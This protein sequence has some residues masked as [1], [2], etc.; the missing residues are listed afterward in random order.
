MNSMRVFSQRIVYTVA[1]AALLLALIIPMVASAATVTERSI[2]L[3]SASKGATNVSYQVA[4]TADQAAGAFVI[5]F[6]SNT[7]L[8]GED[9]DAPAGMSV[10]GAATTTPDYTLTSSDT[11]NPRIVVTSDLAIGE[12]ASLD[13]TGITNPSAS[14]ALYARIVTFTNAT[15]AGASTPTNLAG[16]IDEGAVAIS[17]TESIGVSGTVLETLTFCVSNVAI[18]DVCQTITAPD[19]VLGETAGDV[20]ALTPGQ[21]SED[22]VFTQIS[23]NAV[24]G[25]VVRLKSDAYG[26]GGLLRAGAPEACDIEPALKTGITPGTDAKFGVRTGTATGQTLD[27][28]SSGAFAPVDGSSYNESTFVLN[29]AENEETGVTS[30][31]GDEF[32]DTNN[33]PANSMNMEVVFGAQVTN[34]TPAGTYSADISLIAVGKF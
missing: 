13:I 17:I 11:N 31:F 12:D 25:A 7:P 15:A 28:N 32:L 27:A 26:C 24:N 20:V 33:A 10:T 2:A 18:T 29:F 1:I 23:T 5:D 34:D 3:S 16:K 30:S 4:F 19:V 8:I 14:G 22:S 21:L 6:C 9:C